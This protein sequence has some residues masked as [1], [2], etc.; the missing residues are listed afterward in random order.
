[1]EPTSIAMPNGASASAS[2][3]GSGQPLQTASPH[4]AITTY[5]Y[6]YNGSA[7]TVTATTNGHWV[8]QTTDGLGRVIKVETGDASSTKSVVNTVYGPCA[9][10]PMGKVLQVSLPHGPNDSPQY[11]TYTYDGRGRTL[12]I[13]KPD[14]SLTTYQ[15]TGN[16]TKVID[17][18]GNW[19]IFTMDATGNLVQVTEPDPQLG[20]V[21][22]TYT[23][24]LVN[25][26]TQVQMP[27]AQYGT[28][29]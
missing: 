15:Y 16:T 13:R 7:S 21:N 22:T 2:Y 27:R 14:N 29:V 17:A 24:N 4:G 19:K 8:R 20:N 11:T 28:S 9:C 23:Y 3:D 18:A 6:N 10:S 26:L 12:T 1:M 5:S 25:K